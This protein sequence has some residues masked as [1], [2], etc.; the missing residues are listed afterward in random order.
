MIQLGGQELEKSPVVLRDLV[1]VT[2]SSK[3]DCVGRLW[4]SLFLDGKV[5]FFNGLLPEL[6][7]QIA[8]VPRI[9]AMT[10]FSKH[11]IPKVRAMERQRGDVAHVTP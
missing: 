11:R 9:T 1:G 8:M 6:D 4:F 2:W 3:D 10:S 7:F 5:S